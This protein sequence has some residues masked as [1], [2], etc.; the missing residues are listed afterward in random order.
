MDPALGVMIQERGGH[1]GAAGVVDADEQDLGDVLHDGSFGLG[2]G[3]ELLAGEPVDEQGEEVDHAGALEPV[4]GLVD[5]A[6][7]GLQ[8]PDATELLV[9]GGDGGGEGLAADGVELPRHG[10]ASFEGGRLGGERRYRLGVGDPTPAGD[11][12]SWSP[13]QREQGAGEDTE[14][15]RPEPVV[16]PVAVPLGA[17][18]P[19]LPEHLEM[20]ADQR[21]GGTELVA[22]MTDTEL[23]EC[24]QLEDAP[25]QWISQGAG[26]RSR[27][28]DGVH[29]RGGHRHRWHAHPHQPTLMKPGR[30]ATVQPHRARSEPRPRP[31]R[32][33]R[34]RAA[35][36]ACYRPAPSGQPHRRQ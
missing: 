21:L 6:L 13:G 10:G 5:V 30:Q 26:Q 3:A 11:A 20:V 15:L 2:E 35:L 18:Q 36:A 33:G 29:G 31:S 22:E 8:R 27:R 9:Q 34:P 7:D 17:D 32:V 4:D 16:R 23:L 25:A 28:D 14:G 19:G 12:G 1:L 24:Q